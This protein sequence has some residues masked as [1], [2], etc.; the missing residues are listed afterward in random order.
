MQ[1][2]GIILGPDDSPWEGGIFKLHFKIPDDYPNSPPEVKFLS[3]MFHPNIYKN[4]KICLDILQNQWTAMYDIASILTSLQVL[5]NN[6]NTGSPANTEAAMMFDK[7]P[8][9]YTRKVEECVEESF[10]IS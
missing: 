4:G 1:W 9:E 5:L 7:N 6:P 2:H 8:D 3:R 10:V